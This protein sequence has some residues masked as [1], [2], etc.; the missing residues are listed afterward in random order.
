MADRSEY[1]ALE[2]RNDGKWSRVLQGIDAITLR[3]VWQDT[4]SG[5]SRLWDLAFRRDGNLLFVSGTDGEDIDDGPL[6]LQLF[7]YR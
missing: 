2:G 4:T 1:V 5:S 6:S 7:L 3:P